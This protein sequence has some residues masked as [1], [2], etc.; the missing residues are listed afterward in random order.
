MKYKKIYATPT[1]LL[2]LMQARG[3]D[4][5]DVDDAESLLK[6]IGY[7]RLTGYLF[8]FLENPK[9]DHLFKKE[10]S[11]GKV[12]KI[13]EFD[14]ELRLWVFDQIERIEIA[15]RSAVINTT[16][17]ETNDVFWLSNKLHFASMDKFQKTKSLIDNELLNS[18]EDFILHFKNTYEDSYP[19]SWMIGE[20]IPLGVL[21]RIYENIADYKVKKKVAGYF[22]LSI[23][24]FASWMTIVTLTRNICCHHA[25]LWNRTLSLR[26]L[27]MKRFSYPWVS[28]NV[29]QGRL[30][31]TL[32]IVKHFSDVINPQN[33]LKS[34]LLDL[35]EKYPMIDIRAMGFPDDWQSEDLWQL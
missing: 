14:R 28:L 5:S 27:T 29:Q 26:A 17:A 20:I 32:C 25:R 8:P 6:S 11:I 7:Y 13:Y 2:K 9:S 24:V 34:E 35:L 33:S 16:C 22:G 1:V 4:C 21:T 15:V 18:R 23:P 3:L 30:F 12:K 31:F 10:S 19:P